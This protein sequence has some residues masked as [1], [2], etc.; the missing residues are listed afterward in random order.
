MRKPAIV[1]AFI[2]LFVSLSYALPYSMPIQGQLMSRDGTAQTG[3]YNFRF[4][5]YNYTGSQLQEENINLTLSGRGIFNT[6][7]NTTLPFD[8][9]YSLE[10]YV[11]NQPF[12]KNLTIGTIPYSFRSDMADNLSDYSKINNRI[13]ITG[14]N[15]TSGTISDARL[16]ANVSLLG[17]LINTTELENSSITTIKISDGNVTNAKIDSVAAS[18]VTSG[19]FS[20]GDFTFQ[21]NLLVNNG[22]ANGGA[23]F[24]KSGGFTD[25]WLN[26]S[27]FLINNISSVNVTNI[28]LNGSLLP[29]LNDSYDLGSGSF[30][31]RD[32][33]S[34]RQFFGTHGNFTGSVNLANSGGNVAIGTSGSTVRLTV[35]DASGAGN[36]IINIIGSGDYP[37]IS[38]N[39]G[40]SNKQWGFL[41]SGNNFAIREIG[42]QTPIFFEAGGNVGIGTTGPSNTLQVSGNASIS[43]NL[44]VDTNTLVVDNGN[45]RVGIGTASPNAALQVSGGMN[46]TGR[47]Y[48]ATSSGLV[49]IGT[50]IPTL[51]N[52]LEIYNTNGAQITLIRDYTN[53]DYGASISEAYDDNQ[54]DSLYFGAKS[55]GNPLSNTRMFIGGR[56]GFV[57]IGTTNPASRLDVNGNLTVRTGGLAN[58]AVCWK[59][60]AVTLGYCSSVVAADGTCTCN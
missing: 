39:A 35:S 23:S 30:R 14:E 46:V 32:I 47:A 34:T 52:S 8:T 59:A 7:I 38:T 44:T 9:N 55:N 36:G 28:N 6:L 26:G 58:S 41:Q 1:I 29:S 2:F 60:D 43:G 45:N 21:N 50:A 57:G 54:Y 4:R 25:L 19:T 53:N 31:W 10:I 11:N 22:F 56:N 12:N 40:S 33:Y 15:I 24:L 27:L 18:K 3:T 51:A 13:T 42:V 17:S 5:I 48:F 49:S 16:S 37:I 20:T